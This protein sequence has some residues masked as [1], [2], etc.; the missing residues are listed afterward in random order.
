MSTLGLW[1]RLGYKG[2]TCL[3]YEH[4]W[5]TRATHAW[6]TLTAVVMVD[7][8]TKIFEADRSSD[9]FMGAMCRCRVKVFTCHVTTFFIVV[10]LDFTSSSLEFSSLWTS[11]TARIL[12]FMH[13]VLSHLPP[14]VSTITASAVWGHRIKSPDCLWCFGCFGLFKCDFG[15][16]FNLI[17]KHQWV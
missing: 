6:A 3:G 10:L 13:F 12:I 9:T 7:N 14:R 1:V 11:F 16:L 5:A 4:A 17:R 15:D 2:Y 8:N